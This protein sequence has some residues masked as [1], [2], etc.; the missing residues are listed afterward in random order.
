[1]TTAATTSPTMSGV[2]S[3]LEPVSVPP[4]P[5]LADGAGAA[6]APPDG[7]ADADGSGLGTAVASVR[8]V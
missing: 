1:M 5:G 6:V 8:S 7:A 2:L 3:P 4:P